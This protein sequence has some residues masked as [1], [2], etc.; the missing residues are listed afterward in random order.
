MSI[1]IIEEPEL[2]LTRQEYDRLYREYLQTVMFMVD[3]PSF[4]QFLRGRAATAEYN[5]L[6]GLGSIMKAS[7]P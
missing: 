1:R 2:V 4:E 7:A 6:Q 5:A 3:P